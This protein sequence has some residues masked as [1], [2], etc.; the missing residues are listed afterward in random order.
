[1]L[2]QGFPFTIGAT[3]GGLQP[4]DVSVSFAR[5]GVGNATAQQFQQ[6]TLSFTGSF[7]GHGFINAERAVEGRGAR[8]RRP[9][10]GLQRALLI[11]LRAL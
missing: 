10:G 8:G 11:V 5:P 3:A 7:D 9:L 1:M 4:S 2:L 6:M